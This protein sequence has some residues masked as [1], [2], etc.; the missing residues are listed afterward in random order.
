MS[1]HKRAVQIVKRLRGQPDIGL[2]FRPLLT[3]GVRVC[4]HRVSPSQSRCQTFARRRKELVGGRG[5]AKLV[6]VAGAFSDSSL[7]LGLAPL[8]TRCAL[9]PASPGFTNEAR[10]C[11]VQLPGPWHAH[12]WVCTAIRVQMATRLA[13]LM[14]S[15]TFAG[16]HRGVRRPCGEFPSWRLWW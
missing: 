9:A 5:R 12:C 4:V 7:E 16:P 2:R 14:C 13:S 1:D 6:V 15:V 3:I 8:P 10:S 11:L